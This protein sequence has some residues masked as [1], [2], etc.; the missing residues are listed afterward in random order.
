[1]TELGTTPIP[2]VVVGQLS[3]TT[4][5]RKWSG[6]AESGW[7]LLDCKAGEGRLWANFVVTPLN[8]EWNPYER[9]VSVEGRKKN[10]REWFEVMAPSLI[11]LT[12][13]TLNTDAL[14]G[15]FVAAELV[16]QPGKPEYTTFRF[17]NLFGKGKA[18]MA[19]AE[20]FSAGVFGGG[21]VGSAV[22]TEATVVAGV[23]EDILAYVRPRWEE[24][25]KGNSHLPRA[26]SV[27]KSEEEFGEWLVDEKMGEDDIGI[28]TAD[29][30]GALVG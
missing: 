29:M 14:N 10:A 6:S 7:E 15:Q 5:H 26:V 20:A 18:G 19:A 4:Q 17:T 28:S 30:V 27:K 21:T 22:S 9:Y 23:D 11:S 13:G 16:P 2:D 24:I 25:L 3:I 1:M 12:D 8:P